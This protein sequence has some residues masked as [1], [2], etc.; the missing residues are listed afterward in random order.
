MTKDEIINNNI[1]FF[2]N[3]SGLM[4]KEVFTLL[5]LALC[6]NHHNLRLVSLILLE[7]EQLNF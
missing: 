6:H 3:A 4:F 5:M 2:F 7:F 1:S